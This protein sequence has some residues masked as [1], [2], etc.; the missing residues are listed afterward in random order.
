MMMM[1]TLPLVGE[2]M[3]TFNSDDKNDDTEKEDKKVKHE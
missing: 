1:I 2:M 3:T